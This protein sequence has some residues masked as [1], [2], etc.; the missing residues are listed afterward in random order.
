M[1]EIWPH[2]DEYQAKTERVIPVVVLERSERS[3]VYRSR[4]MDRIGGIGV[5]IAVGWNIAI[6]GPIATRLSHAYGVSLTTIG[7]FVTVQFVVHMVMQVPGGRAA[8]R[9]GARTSALVGLGLILVGNAVSLPAPQPALAFLGRAIVGL[10]TG[11]AFVGGSDYI[12]ARGGSPFLQG[13]YGG[14]SVLAPGHRRRRRPAARRLARLA[15]AVSQRDR[16]RRG[17][18]ALLALAPAGGAHR[19]PRRRAARPR[20]S[21]ATAGSTGSRAIHAMSFGFSVIVGNWVVTLL[22]H[23]GHSKSSA[24]LAGSLTLVLGFFTRAAGGSAAAPARRVALGRREPR[25]RRPRRR[26]ARAAASV[27]GARR[28]RGGRRPRRRRPVRDGLHRRGAGPSRTR[29][30]LPSASSTRGPRS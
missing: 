28:R 8:D 15:G 10:G 18:R 2:Y 16:R 1:N 29:P 24:S 5:G 14:G 13:L 17:L 4:V 7:L 12:R 11:F 26:R 22:E 21:F 30:A 25:R 6:L 23:H 19:A 27:L 20:A 3:D 9:F